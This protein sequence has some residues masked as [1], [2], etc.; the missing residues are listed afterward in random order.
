[1]RTA[2]LPETRAGLRT[3]AAQSE[4]DVFSRPEEGG[5]ALNA[6]SWLSD[7]GRVLTS[8]AHDRAVQWDVCTHR[9]IRSVQVWET[10]RPRLPAATVPAGDG[11]V[12]AVGIDAGAR[13][14]H[15]ATPHLA[16]R[17]RP[18]EPDLAAAEVCAR[19]EGG[20]TAA[21]W[22]KYLPSVPYRDSCRT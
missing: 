16:D 7:D 14:L 11:P 6:P 4:Q 20:A 5:R 18:L 22:R 2:D 10:A 8:V 1:M 15:I 12:L 19:A 9:R 17:V 3:A 13:E 21:E